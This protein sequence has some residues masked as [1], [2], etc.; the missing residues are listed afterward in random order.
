M[1]RLPEV[2]CPDAEATLSPRSPR[3][4]RPQG[5]GQGPAHMFPSRL[6]RFPA[7]SAPSCRKFSSDVW[8][9]GRGLTSPHVSQSRPRTTAPQTAGEFGSTKPGTMYPRGQG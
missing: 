6:D 3:G 5:R 2:A 8:K 7:A 4:I 1:G 9:E